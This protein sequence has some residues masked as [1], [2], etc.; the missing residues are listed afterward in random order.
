MPTTNELGFP[1]PV[2]D[3]SP[4]VP[5]DILALASAVSQDVYP[6][7]TTA[8]ERDSAFTKWGFQQCSVSGIHYRR[9]GALWL[10]CGG[11]GWGGATIPSL[12]NQGVNPN[13]WVKAVMGT[14]GGTIDGDGVVVHA[15]GL[16][17]V[18]ASAGRYQCSAFGAWEAS[19]SG[20]RRL[21]A[22][23]AQTLT[24]P[25][26]LCRGGSTPWGAS[27]RTEVSCAGE[28]IVDGPSVIS[29]FLQHDAAAPIQMQTR[30]LQVRRVA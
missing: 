17:I 21:I 9:I 20:T 10:Q 28:V 19:A 1:A 11:V 6:K 26:F 2:I 5:R 30:S 8:A 12:V 14:S 27:A 7:F 4:D 3:D 16:G 24:D 15:G 22:I 13:I 29:M 18:V 25:G 23:N